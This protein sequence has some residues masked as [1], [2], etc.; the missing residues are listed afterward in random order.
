L[1]G[2]GRPILPISTGKMRQD[3]GEPQLG[4]GIIVM[5][6]VSKNKDAGDSEVR[7]LIKM[8]HYALTRSGSPS[9]SLAH[10]LVMRSHEELFFQAYF[11]DFMFQ[12]PFSRFIRVYLIVYNSVD[13]FEWH[14]LTK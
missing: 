4:F 14:R 10:S 1:D 6:V 5:V 11:R 9:Y 7:L 8:Q 2:S 3:L 13:S 12:L